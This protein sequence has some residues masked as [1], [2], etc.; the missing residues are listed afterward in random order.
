VYLVNTLDA[1]A[2]VGYTNWGAAS[3][4]NEGLFLA[5]Y[6][7]ESPPIFGSHNAKDLRKLDPKFT[8]SLRYNDAVCVVMGEFRADFGRIL[9]VWGR[10]LFPGK[11]S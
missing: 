2:L 9:G 5:A 11:P 6:Y 8:L 7:A 1:A 4:V 3:Y 10:K